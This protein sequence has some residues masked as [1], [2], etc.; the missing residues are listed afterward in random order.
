MNS[1]KKYQL[2]NFV[3][4]EKEEIRICKMVE[5]IMPAIKKNNPTFAEAR[6]AIRRCG[7]ELETMKI[8]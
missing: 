2:E 8:I 5:D 1:V 4:D 7:I 6:E 3:F